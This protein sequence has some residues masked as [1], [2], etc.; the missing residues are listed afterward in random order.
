MLT[1]HAVL[2]RYIF[3]R[4]YRQWGWLVLEHWRDIVVNASRAFEQDQQNVTS[5]GPLRHARMPHS[6]TFALAR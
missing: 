4:G 5:T 6:C 2:R 1:R 3:C